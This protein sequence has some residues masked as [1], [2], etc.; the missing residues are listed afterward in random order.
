M[1]MRVLHIFLASCVA[2]LA[3]LSA[4]ACGLD[5]GAPVDAVGAADTELKAQFP[6]VATMLVRRCGTIDCHGSKYRN[7]RVYGY[8]GIRLDAAHTPESPPTTTQAEADATYEGL[9]SLEPEIMRRVVDARAAGREQ[10]TLY[11][12]ARGDEDHKG[13]KLWATGDEADLCFATWLART[14]DVAKCDA[15]TKAK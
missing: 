10:L 3:C 12:K 14:T 7:F 8:G 2:G 9:L 5:E 11:R 4:T 15:A 6:P 1:M 13:D